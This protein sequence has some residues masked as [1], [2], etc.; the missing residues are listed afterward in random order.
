MLD[1][2]GRNPPLPG[3]VYRYS[4]LESPVVL[5]VS[6]EWL[7]VS[8]IIAA[9]AEEDQCPSIP[10]NITAISILFGDEL[11]YGVKI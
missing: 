11:V 9:L 6:S 5:S 4:R 1:I 8:L 7:K 2:T 10:P 3:I